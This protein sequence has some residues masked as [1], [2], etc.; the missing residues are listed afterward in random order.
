MAKLG[1]NGIPGGRMGRVHLHVDCNFGDTRAEEIGRLGKALLAQLLA[2]MLYRAEHQAKMS[3]GHAVLGEE[4]PIR[5][6]IAAF[7]REELKCRASVRCAEEAH[8]R[9][10]IGHRERELVQNAEERGQL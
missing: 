9:G 5:N 10:D 6:G 8:M 7:S 2:N 1:A 4:K 3:S